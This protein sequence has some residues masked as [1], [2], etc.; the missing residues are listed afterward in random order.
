[1]QNW[2]TGETVQAGFMQAVVKAQLLDSV[3]I[4]S[5]RIGTKLYTFTPYYGIREVSPEQAARL[6]ADDKARRQAITAS[7]AAEHAKRDAINA[8]FA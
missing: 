2:K 6:L 1:M 4:L 7:I 8:I 5:N 3:F